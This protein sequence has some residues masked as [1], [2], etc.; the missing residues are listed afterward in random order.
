[1]GDVAC[2]ERDEGK[3]ASKA[4]DAVVPG[5]EPGKKTKS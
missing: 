3:K 5:V 1:M 4:S 2:V